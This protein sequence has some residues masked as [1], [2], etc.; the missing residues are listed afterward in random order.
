MKHSF[1]LRFAVEMLFRDRFGMTIEDALKKLYGPKWEEEGYDVDINMDKR[2][3][4]M[5]GELKKVT[6]K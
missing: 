1:G 6:K 5:L 4:F 2:F 3:H